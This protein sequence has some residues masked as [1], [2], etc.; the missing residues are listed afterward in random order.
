MKKIGKQLIKSLSLM[1]FVMIIFLGGLE[2]GKVK[3]WIYPLVRS[4]QHEWIG[5]KIRNYKTLETPHFFIRYNKGNKTE[6]NLVA[7]AAEKHYESICDMF[8][9]YP[10][11]KIL[12][13]VYHDAQELMHNTYL[14]QGKP[15]MGVY[16]ASTIQILSPT[17][18]IP[19]NENIKEVF[20]K[21]GP[22]VHEF[23]HLLVDDLARG[24]YPLWFTEGIALYQE[25][26]QTG[27]EWGENL[28]LGEPSYTAEEL[29]K[30]F[31][32]LDE[33]VAY[34]RSFE[35]VKDLVEIKDFNHFNQILEELGKG[36]DFFCANQKIFGNDVKNILKE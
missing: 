31:S 30:E 9:Y 3:V 16:Y 27:Y 33:M 13:I 26:I 17:L 4:I 21:E 14:K 7:E 25:Y 2:G 10:K 20:M 11:K 35:L 24:N 23:T 32:N 6:M 19:E 22:M 29:T 1:L 34:R 18:W 15:P 5:Y 28:N 8:H 12:V 36:M